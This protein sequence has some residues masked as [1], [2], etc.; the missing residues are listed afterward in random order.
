LRV[1][2]YM[3][4]HM[5][6]IWDRLEIECRQRFQK[7]LFPQGLGYTQVEGFG[8]AASS[9]FINDLCAGDD[10]KSQMAR[11]PGVRWNQIA[12]FLGEL[13]NLNDLLLGAA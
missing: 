4:R 5:L 9:L 10:E 6:E 3:F 8:T 11:P 2:E 7:T 1:A 13:Q 12:Q